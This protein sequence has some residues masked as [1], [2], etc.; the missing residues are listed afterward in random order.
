M[1]SAKMASIV[2]KLTTDY[3]PFNLLSPPR[4]AQ[5]ADVLRIMEMREGEL[6]QVKP[7]TARDYLFVVEGYIEVI[8]DGA[9]RSQAA[10]GTTRRRPLVLP[11]A[12]EKTTLLAA[13]DSILC[14][15][16]SASLDRLLS[17]DEMLVLSEQADAE[18]HERLDNVRD[19]LAFKRMPLE[20]VETAFKCMR[21]MNA[22]QG[23][24]VVRQ[25][26]QGD[27]FYIMTSGRA[28]LWQ[29]GLYDDEPHKIADLGDGDTFGCE[30]LLSGKARSETVRITEDATLLVLNKEDFDRLVGKQLV[31]RMHPKIA[32]SMIDTGYKI[33]DVR[34]AEEYEGGH[35]P[36]AILMPLHEM[37]D[38]MHELDK[39][40]RYIVYCHAGGRSAVAALKLSQN[41]HDVVSLDGGIAAWPYQQETL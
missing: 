7:G 31:R 20:C 32:K 29:Q 1:Q 19:S 11:R 5:V 39:S 18:L 9:I 2:H 38:R 24:T 28:E 16:D 23:E 27:S 8:S 21:T 41:G 36:G 33:L 12:P 22:R 25:G 13:S 14:L 6:F 4:A 15:A 40:A 35:I 26:E 34:Y 37:R 17:W 3:G 30:A 10:P